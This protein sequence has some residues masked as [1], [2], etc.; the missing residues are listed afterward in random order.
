MLDSLRRPKRVALALMALVLHLLLPFAHAL[1]RSTLA[2]GTPVLCSVVPLSPVTPEPD[3]HAA[4]VL[5]LCPVCVGTSGLV[6]A[7]PPVPPALPSLHH[8]AS[9]LRLAGTEGFFLAAP[10]RVLPPAQAPPVQPD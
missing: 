8:A 7:P 1:E 5:P 2:S 3:R 9:L 10:D 4:P 6:L